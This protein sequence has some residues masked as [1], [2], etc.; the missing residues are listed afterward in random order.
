MNEATTAGAR[1]AYACLLI[2]LSIRTSQRWRVGGVVH[3]DQRPIRQHESSHKLTST[4][5]AE[6]L[7]VA[8]STEF[9]HLP[10]SQIVPRLADK[11]RYIASESTFYPVLKA[12]HQLAHRRSERPA[13]SHHK[14]KASANEHF[15][16]DGI[17]RLVLL[18]SRLAFWRDHSFKP[19]EL[20]LYYRTLNKLIG[21]VIEQ[22][23]SI[24]NFSLSEMFDDK[25]ALEKL[26]TL[27]QVLH[28][29]TEIKMEES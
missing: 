11:G 9:G 22:L 7:V 24:D 17:E 27:Y 15:P 10:P 29:N 12:T 18:I 1:L 3:S 13:Q 21:R 4:K 26:L 19:E 5:L 23:T 28:V 14:P 16:I 2:G 25:S 20:Y 8:N 6:L